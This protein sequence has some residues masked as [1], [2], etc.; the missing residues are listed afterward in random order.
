M[1]FGIALFGASWFD[2]AWLGIVYLERLA[3]QPA[4]SPA[5]HATSLL[6]QETRIWRFLRSRFGTRALAECLKF[7]CRTTPQTAAKKPLPSFCLQADSLPF[8]PRWRHQPD[9]ASWLAHAPQA[10]PCGI[11]RRQTLPHQLPLLRPLRPL[12]LHESAP[13]RRSLGTALPQPPSSWPLPRLES[14]KSFSQPCW[15]CLCPLPIPNPQP[16]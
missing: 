9:I 5:F 15:L 16:S 4:Y 12:H 6:P 11:R 10:N 7:R 2:S 1:R 3:F 14:K 8:C 13:S